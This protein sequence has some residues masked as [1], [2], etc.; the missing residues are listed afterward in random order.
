MAYVNES[1]RMNT[2]IKSD[3]RIILHLRQW[4][5]LNVEEKERRKEEEK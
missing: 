1:A 4:H 3:R 5:K 2:I